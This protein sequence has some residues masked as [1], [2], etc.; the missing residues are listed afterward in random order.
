MKFLIYQIFYITASCNKGLDS[1]TCTDHDDNVYCKNCH[2]KLFGPK[3]Y[4]FAAGASGLSMDTGNPGEVTKEWVQCVLNS[5][6][7]R[8]IEDG[9]KTYT[10]CG[11]K[12]WDFMILFLCIDLS[13][14]LLQ[15]MN[16]DPSARNRCRTIWNFYLCRQRRKQV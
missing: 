8:R 3:G 1:T 13:Q 12:S 11:G 2:G 9:E 6:Y 7:V 10:L 15:T 16:L 5:N 14:N 4:G